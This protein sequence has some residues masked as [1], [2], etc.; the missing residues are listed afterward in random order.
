MPRPSRRHV[1]VHALLAGV[2]SACSKSTSDA[3][4]DPR[5]SGSTGPDDVRRALDR[6]RA[7]LRALQAGPLQVWAAG[8]DEGGG[9]GAGPA[10]VLCHGYGARGDDLVSLARSVDASPAVRWFFP[11]APQAVDG[12]GGESGRAWWPIDMAAIRAGRR[13]PPDDA[14]AGLD[15]ARDALA[16]CLGALAR[17]EGVRPERLVV[18]GFSQGAMLA[19]DWV[20]AARPGVAG[21]AALSGTL[22]NAARWR[23]DA[24]AGAARGL[25]A[26]VTHGTEDAVLPF[27]LAES[28]RD[29]LAGGGAR[30]A[31]HSFRGGHAIPTAA[32][33]ALAAFLRRRFGEGR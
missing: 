13:P 18:G 29:L 9:R 4:P 33:D 25:E 16:A 8:G 6:R 23:A 7:A 19:T 17:D 30:V 22:V 10:V 27:A 2:G 26:C 31:F 5:P 11:A 20:L 14:P 28:V 21:L 1:L 3:P 24:A 32:H 12:G 15:A